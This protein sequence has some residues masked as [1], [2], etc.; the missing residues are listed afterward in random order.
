MAAFHAAGEIY[1]STGSYV[2][3]F[4]VLGLSIGVSGA[5]LFFLPCVT[6]CSREKSVALHDVE[7]GKRIGVPPEA[8]E[9]AEGGVHEEMVTLRQHLD[10]GGS[11][12][13]GGEEPVEA[14]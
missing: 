2:W 13:G 10:S 12:G 5:I 4:V 3:P 11:G 14:K 6:S 7:M 1:D 9:G 8:I